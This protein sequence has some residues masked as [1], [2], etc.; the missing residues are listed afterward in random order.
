MI[1]L[2]LSILPKTWL[3]DID[4]T[5]FKHNG[6][7]AGKEEVIEE[8]KKFIGRIP[9]SDFII[10]LTSRSSEF[11]QSTETEL[12]KWGIRF[13][14]VV[15]G[16]PVGERVLINDKKPRGLSTAVAVNVERDKFTPII[17]DYSS[18]L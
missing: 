18:E 7:L 1:R 9:E 6:H 4:G 8:A 11:K 5:I 10:L 3:I 13:N 17:I 12:K 15:Y 2:T 16:L 14:Q